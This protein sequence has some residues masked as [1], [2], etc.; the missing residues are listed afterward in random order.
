MTVIKNANNR[1]SRNTSL[2]FTLTNEGSVIIKTNLGDEF[3]V[4]QFCTM[5]YYILKGKYTP[6]IEQSLVL[7]SNRV[8]N[9]G[10]AEMTIAQ[11]RQI[12]DQENKPIVSPLDTFNNL[13]K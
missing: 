7:A 4:E 12:L 2:R 10:I 1:K 6:V 9:P 3:S 11:L 8:G 5:I 13:T